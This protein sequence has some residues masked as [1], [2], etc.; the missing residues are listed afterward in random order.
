MRPFLLA[1]IQSTLQLGG[2]NT[3]ESYGVVN[4]QAEV[5]DTPPSRIH[6]K[7]RKVY[8]G[9]RDGLYCFAAR[10]LSEEII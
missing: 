6:T 9:A 3:P 2:S 8:A 7:T 1:P 4:V 5:R 10:L